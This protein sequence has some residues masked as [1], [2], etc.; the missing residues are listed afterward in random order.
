[1][2]ITFP[3][4]TSVISALAI[5]LVG[6]SQPEIS[7][8]AKP[9]ISVQTIHENTLVIDSHIDLELDLIAE[10]MDPWSSGKSRTDLAKNESRRHG[11]CI[12][13]RVFPAR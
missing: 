7:T 13:D 9:T 11:W 3:K 5:M 4:N 1:M 8:E 2:P 6:C 12:P 10:D